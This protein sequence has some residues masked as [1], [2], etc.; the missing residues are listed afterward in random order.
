M[1]AILEIFLECAPTLGCFS[2]R[3]LHEAGCITIDRDAE[4]LLKNYDGSPLA[5]SWD[6]CRTSPAMIVQR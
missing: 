4:D 6:L 2:D 5:T 1:L 3:G